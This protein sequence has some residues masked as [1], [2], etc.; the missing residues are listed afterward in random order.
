V[1]AAFVIGVQVVVVVV[2]PPAVLD[3]ARID[4]RAGGGGVAAVGD[5]GGIFPIVDAAAD[6]V[7]GAGCVD[8]QVTRF[9]LFL[10]VVAV[11]VPVG[12]VG[13]DGCFLGVLPSSLPLLLLLE[14]PPRAPP[15]LMAAEVGKVVVAPLT[16]FS[17]SSLLLDFFDGFPDGRGGGGPRFFFRPW[18]SS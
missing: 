1:L 4:N 3:V 15:V 7:D 12:P 6:D 5:G 8:P 16:A 14:P 18:P 17:S 11:A 13:G 2:V 10:A 9:F